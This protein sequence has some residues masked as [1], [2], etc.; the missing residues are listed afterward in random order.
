MR[1]E[2]SS[3]S[4]E[5]EQV[6]SRN[7]VLCQ[8]FSVA[9]VNYGS[10]EN[11]ANSLRN[12]LISAVS[13]VQAKSQR[14]ETLSSEVTQLNRNAESRQLLHQ[15]VLSEAQSRYEMNM[16]TQEVRA[17]QAISEANAR[18][19]IGSPNPTHSS[20]IAQMQQDVNIARM[21]YRTQSQ[22]CQTQNAKIV[23][24]EE[25]AQQHAQQIQL[26]DQTIASLQQDKNDL[27]KRLDESSKN[28]EEDVQQYN[29]TIR[30]LKQENVKLSHEVE[31]LQEY[32]QQAY[33]DA[34]YEDVMYHGYHGM[35]NY[36]MQASS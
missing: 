3:W 35:Q 4:H 24:L 22:E 5:A 16:H 32:I 9:K 7:T 10:L 8:E 6:A 1:N 15:S 26:R 33:G 19:M 2:V 34:E 13:E 27:Q 17:Q 31:E 29:I 25:S 36:Q 18:I 11:E 28:H 21:E 30:A 20:Q 23:Q 14:A 12:Q